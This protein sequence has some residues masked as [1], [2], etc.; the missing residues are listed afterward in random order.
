M[1][2]NVTLINRKDTMT[3]EISKNLTQLQ[4]KAKYLDY[5][6]EVAMHVENSGG[7]TTYLPYVRYTQ[8]DWPRIQ[9]GGWLGEVFGALLK[10]EPVSFGYTI[11]SAI[12]KVEDLERSFIPEGTFFKAV[13]SGP[14]EEIYRTY[15][16]ML[17]WIYSQNFEIANESIEFITHRSEF[18]GEQDIIILIPMLE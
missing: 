14:Y 16:S 3:M 6:S 11:V 10:K 1:L 12:G 7:M 4:V 17:D 18:G 9:K 13:H 2:N 15:R 5:T 8:R